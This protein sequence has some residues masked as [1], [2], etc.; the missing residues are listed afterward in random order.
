MKFTSK[1]GSRLPSGDKLGLARSWGAT[2]RW[3]NDAE[4]ASVDGFL[5]RAAAELAAGGRRPYLIP[6]G[7]ATALGAIGYAL[8]AAELHDQLAGRGLRASCVLVAVGSGGTLAGLIAGNALL[9]RPWRLVGASV[10][11]PPAEA[12]R[13]VLELATECASL[14][15]APHPGGPKSAGQV[16]QKSPRGGGARGETANRPAPVLGQRVR[17]KSSRGLNLLPSLF[18]GA[19]ASC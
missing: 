11:R 9:G 3:T 4:R 17:R 12:A 7:G 8:A 2:V 1:D 13:R 18:H 15:A 16:T 5:P 19:S 6:R 14:L 10:S